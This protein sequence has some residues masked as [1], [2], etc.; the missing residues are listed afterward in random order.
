MLKISIFCNHLIEDIMHIFLEQKLKLFMR[1]YLKSPMPSIYQKLS[2]LLCDIRENWIRERERDSERVS[3]LCWL[4]RKMFHLKTE[5]KCVSVLYLAE[6]KTEENISKSSVPSE[7]R[8]ES[9]P[10]PTDLKYQLMQQ[11]SKT[12]WIGF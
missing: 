7:D 1:L 11:N 10:K 8:Q 2:F 12:S 5:I 3:Q 9:L 6:T 4:C